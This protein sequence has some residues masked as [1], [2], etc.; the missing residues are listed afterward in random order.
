MLGLSQP[1]CTV[2]P[3]WKAECCAAAL[4]AAWL[5][6]TTHGASG[7]SQFLAICEAVHV[8]VGVAQLWRP[9][10]A[11]CLKRLPGQWLCGGEG[12]GRLMGALPGRSGGS[13]AQLA[14]MAKHIM[15]LQEE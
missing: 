8:A 4:K 11:G 12:R 6:G 13:H 3:A 2:V 1:E 14:G 15:Q 7:V 10:V 9:L 5:V